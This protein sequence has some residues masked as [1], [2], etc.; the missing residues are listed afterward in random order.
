MNLIELD[1]KKVEMFRS[2]PNFTWLSIWLSS[3]KRPSSM[4]KLNGPLTWICVRSV[5]TD[6]A[7]S[8]IVS[9][10][11]SHGHPMESSWL[12]NKA[13]AAVWLAIWD[14][15]NMLNN[16]PAALVM[17]FSLEFI[18]EKDSKSFMHKK[19]SYL[20]KRSSQNKSAEDRLFTLGDSFVGLLLLV[21]TWLK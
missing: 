6:T 13:P 17:L 3:I 10:W 9:G 11:T 12:N 14:C 5:K 20:A 4:P 16:K 19:F 7:D 1:L 18:L 15:K 8:T 21:D 2:S